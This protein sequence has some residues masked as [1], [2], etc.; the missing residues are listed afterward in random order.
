[1]TFTPY[2]LGT[3]PDFEKCLPDIEVQEGV[4]WDSGPGPSRAFSDDAH[5]PGGKTME[6]ITQKEYFQDRIEWGLPIQPVRQMSKD[7][8][9]TIY[10]TRYWLPY[11]PKFTDPGMKL[12]F[13]NMSVNGGVGRAIKELQIVLHISTVG[14]WGPQTEAAVTSLD[15]SGDGPRAV[16]DYKNACDAF[17]KAIPGF[18]WFGKDWL[19]RDN[20]IEKNASDLDKALDAFVADKPPS[21]MKDG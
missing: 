5:D 19:R 1:M 8:E 18:K 11:C 2:K 21:I 16:I 3:D 10:Y 14:G 15:A 12:E 17:Y 7:E 9:R 6:G 4:K 20:E 13:F